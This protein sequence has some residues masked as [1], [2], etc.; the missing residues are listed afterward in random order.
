M[1]TKTNRRSITISEP[2]AKR[3]TEEAEARI[4][5]RDKLADLL[6]EAGLDRLPPAVVALTPGPT[7]AEGR[8]PGHPDELR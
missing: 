6:I 3:L 8:A 4:L 7:P 1:T 5:G 2:L